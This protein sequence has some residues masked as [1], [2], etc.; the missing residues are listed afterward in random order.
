MNSIP[1]GYGSIYN[2]ENQVI[3]SGFLYEGKKFFFGIEFFA[4]IDT[5]Q[6]FG[7]FC[8]DMRFGYGKL[9]NRKNELIFD[10]EWYNNNPVINDI[11]MITD[12]LKDENTLLY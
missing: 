6:Y 10:G 9:Y 4:D 12:E 7:E 5:I 11:C 3:F 1:F 8:N 2:E